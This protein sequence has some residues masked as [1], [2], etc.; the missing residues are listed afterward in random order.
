M[1]PPPEIKQ[2]GAG[3]ADLLDRS[4]PGKAQIKYT[5]AESSA[6]VT[7]FPR[8]RAARRQFASLRIKEISTVALLRRRKDSVV[9][10]IIFAS[11]LA[12]HLACDQTG[13]VYT[14]AERGKQRP[15]PWMGLSLETLRRVIV[16]AELGGFADDELLTIITDVTAWREKHGTSLPT[17]RKLGRDLQLT[18]IEREACNIRTIEAVDES[19]E[20]RK[21]RLREA[22][23][24][25]DR[26]RKRVERGAIPREIYEQN[27]FSQT[28]PW[29][30]EGIKRRAWEKRRAKR[31]ACV[32][33]II[34]SYAGTHLR[35][36]ADQIGNKP[37]PGPARRDC[38][39]QDVGAGGPS[40]GATWKADAA[41]RS[42]S[43]AAAEG[44]EVAG[45]GTSTSFPA[46]VLRLAQEAH[47]IV[48]DE[49]E[50]ELSLRMCCSVIRIGFEAE[51]DTIEDDAA[52][53]AVEMRRVLRPRAANDNRL[54]SILSRLA[55]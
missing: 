53:I 33:P 6:T 29:E 48:L 24:I 36:A 17:A 14:K 30:A 41:S 25:R 32:S 40:S 9:D 38:L 50:T 27:S 1:R 22:K 4:A 16:S 15:V 34:D 47:A 11:V 44:E 43:D 18:A 45:C 35:T 20:E 8:D 10:G 3:N 23:L 5:E 21:A 37:S 12:F 26:E 7:T 51:S 28:K 13:R 55:A 54:A 46:R 31:Y 42:G 2:A 19:K 49:P 39:R 52:V